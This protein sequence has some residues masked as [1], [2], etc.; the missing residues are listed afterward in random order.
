MSP[1]IKV[2]RVD[3]SASDWLGG[4]IGLTLAERGVYVTAC[5]L[6]YMHCGPITRADCGAHVRARARLQPRLKAPRRTGKADCDEDGKIDQKR[7]EI[8]LERAKKRIENGRLGG[9]P[10]G[11]NGR[12]TVH[13]TYPKSDEKLDKKLAPERRNSQ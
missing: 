1:P 5:A 10:P 3:F 4:T 11:G 6:I 12:K 8:E 9:G 2:Q 7:C 13:K